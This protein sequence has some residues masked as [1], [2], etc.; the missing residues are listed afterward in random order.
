MP[1][2]DSLISVPCLFWVVHHAERDAYGKGWRLMLQILR[3][4][5][6]ESWT[7]SEAGGKRGSAEGRQ[8]QH[9]GICDIVF[10]LRNES[11]LRRT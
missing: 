6:I 2:D 11:L 7:V 8:G 4:R 3:N 5:E 10:F 9:Y 1:R